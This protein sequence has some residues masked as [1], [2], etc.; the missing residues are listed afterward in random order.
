MFHVM[1]R[2]IVLCYV[3]CYMMSHYHAWYYTSWH[4]VM[5]RYVHVLSFGKFIDVFRIKILFSNQ[6]KCPFISRKLRYATSY[7]VILYHVTSLHTILHHVMSCKVTFSHVT[8][9]TS[10]CA[11]LYSAQV[12]GTLSISRF[13]WLQLTPT[14]GVS[15][16]I[17]LISITLLKCSEQK[18]NVYLLYFSDEGLC[19]ISY[20]RCDLVWMEE[21]AAWITGEKMN[22]ILIIQSQMTN[23]NMEA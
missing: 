12:S 1:L 10:D 4:H 23:C 17:T 8:K 14:H 13:R 11:L 7:H 3:L 16:R 2:Y 9:A 15:T 20:R 6:I 18:C 5:S 19:L 22:R 21:N